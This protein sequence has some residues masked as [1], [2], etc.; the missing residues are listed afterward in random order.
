M[1]ALKGKEF[2]SKELVRKISRE[3]YNKIRVESGNKMQQIASQ[4]I[5][6]KR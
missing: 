3:K 5:V 1:T 2:L 4:N 6:T